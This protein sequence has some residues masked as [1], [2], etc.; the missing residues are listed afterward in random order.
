MKKE[1][2]DP[3]FSN[4]SGPSD[5]SPPSFNNESSDNLNNLSLRE[6]RIDN[7]IR[8]GEIERYERIKRSF[9]LNVIQGELEEVKMKIKRNIDVNMVDVV[10][11]PILLIA[12]GSLRYSENTNKKNK[13]LDIIVE[14]LNAGSDPYKTDSYGCTAYDILLDEE[15]SNIL[16]NHGSKIY[17]NNLMSE[18]DSINQQVLP[19]E[20]L[21]MV[22]LRRDLELTCYDENNSKYTAAVIGK[23][24]NVDFSNSMTKK[25]ICPLVS[26]SI[27][28]GRKY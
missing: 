16:L 26:K 6:R 3:I 24:L 4:S 7:A 10:G 28:S 25:E 5:L 11:T 20:I 22:L 13:I 21:E 23:Y 14:L 1:I 18:I 15:V 17:R 2:F 8:K 12:V 19:K 27:S 9:M